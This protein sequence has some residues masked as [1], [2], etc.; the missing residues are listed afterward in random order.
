MVARED[1]AVPARKVRMNLWTALLESLHSA[2]IDELCE[3]H[4]EPKPELGMPVRK[5]RFELPD[6]GVADFV[7]CV[8]LQGEIQGIGCIAMTSACEKTLGLGPKELW[9]A[10]MKRAGAEFSRRQIKP[11]V[12]QLAELKGSAPL[13]KSFPEVSRMIWIP[14][15]FPSGSCYLGM[16]V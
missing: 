9:E 3:R 11:R 5:S 14:V 8:V 10:C 7:A 16:G 1:P 2:L 15:R 4:P 12:A 13:P 6:A